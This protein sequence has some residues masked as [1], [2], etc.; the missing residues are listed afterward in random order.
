VSDLILQLAEYL[1]DSVRVLFITGAGISADSGL[2]TYRGVGGLYNDKQTT[3]GYSIEQCLSASMFSRHPEITWKYMLP[4]AEAVFRCEPND[5]HRV[6]AKL[7]ADFA[8]RGGKVV[9]FTQ[10]IDGYHKQAGSKVVL[11]IHGT[12]RTLFCTSSNCDWSEQFEID[13]AE[14]QNKEIKNAKLIQRIEKFKENLYS[15]CSEIPETGYAD[16]VSRGDCSRAK[17]TVCTG[18]GKP[19]CCPVC[20]SVIRPDVVLFEE[21]LPYDV[22]SEFDREFDD[23]KGFDLIISVGTSAMFPY[24]TAPI[25]EAVKRGKKTVDINPS[26]SNLSKTVSLHIP[27]T[28]AKTFRELEKYIP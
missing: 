15:S 14:D 20:G 24:I 9:V 10:N 4:I 16:A 7:E 26:E 3:E 18:F 12:L 11:E 21:S 2:P 28:A 1:R 17:P 8:K 5:A 6:I 22:L 19:P 13:S 25:Y 23:G 27:E